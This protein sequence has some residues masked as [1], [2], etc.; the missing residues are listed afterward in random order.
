MAYLM[1]T[2]YHYLLEIDGFLFFAAQKYQKFNNVAT[3][4]VIASA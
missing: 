1:K 3:L 4:V 2:T